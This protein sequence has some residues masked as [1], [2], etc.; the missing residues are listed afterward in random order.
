MSDGDGPGGAVLTMLKVVALVIALTAMVG[1]G[2]C[3]L[4]GVVLGGWFSFDTGL[5]GL[6]LLGIVIALICF[7]IFR[8]IVRSLRPK[9]P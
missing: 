1:F 7:A 8:A 9:Q 5:L 3:G 4:F 2:A 6:G